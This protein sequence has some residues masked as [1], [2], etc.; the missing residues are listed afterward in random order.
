MEFHSTSHWK[1]VTCLADIKNGSQDFVKE[2]TATATHYPVPHHKQI[3]VKRT[4]DISR[5]AQSMNWN[6][7][8]RFI[9]HLNYIRINLAFSLFLVLTGDFENVELLE[10][11]SSPRH[12]NH[13]SNWHVWESSIQSQLKLLYRLNLHIFSPKQNKLLTYQLIMIMSIPMHRQYTS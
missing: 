10:M 2:V 7:E 8:T 5:L 12:S 11:F 13:F 6:L 1:T 3:K 9:L 4:W